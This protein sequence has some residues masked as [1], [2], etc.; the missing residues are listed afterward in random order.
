MPGAAEVLVV[1]DEPE[2]LSYMETLLTVEGHHVTTSASG[3]L[4]LQRLRQGLIPDLIF[5]DVRMPG[6]DG[7]QSLREI[8]RIRPGAQVVMLSCLS[9][10]RTVVEAMR[11]GAQDYLTK[12]FTRESLDFTIARC[13]EPGYASGTSVP[14]SCPTIDELRDGR[15]MLAA[16]KAMSR[17]RALCE[18][19]AGVDVPVLILGESGTGKEVVARFIHERSLRAA[20]PFL[21]INL[22]AMPADLLESELFGYEPGAF[23]GATHAKPGKF[24]L[25]HNGTILLDEIGDMPPVLQAKLLHVLQDGQFYRLGGRRS[26]TVDVRVLAAT[27]IDIK[28]AIA[29]HRFREDL[30][31]RLNAMT[32]NVP[33]LRERKEEISL[34]L[35][36]FMARVSEE[37]GMSPLPLSSSLL[38]ACMSYS[39]PGNVRELE[40][41]VKRYLVLRDEREAVAEVEGLIRMQER[42]RPVSRLTVSEPLKSVARSAKDAAEIV[43]IKDALETT[44]WHRKRAAE[45]LNISYKALLYKIRQYQIK[46]QTSCD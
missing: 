43:A 14:A 41:F 7:L 11:L 9:E 38:S 33:A 27:N 18:M 42:I 2:L 29:E 19:V 24:E 25:C 35:K 30:Y 28:A 17:V 39:W 12:P 45:L 3:L 5:L 4:A 44:K 1:D 20:Q 8:R 23:T 34:L 36:H 10:T 26:L 37:Y 21:K 32:I 31:Y 22:A 16:G 6:L 13:L 46:P 15:V 40:N